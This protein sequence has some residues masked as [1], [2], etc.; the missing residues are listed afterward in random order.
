MIDFWKEAKKLLP[1]LGKKPH[2][3]V[4]P[5]KVMCPFPRFHYDHELSSHHVGKLMAMKLGLSCTSARCQGYSI[6]S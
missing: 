1:Y 3:L 2:V 6:I 5:D 4:V